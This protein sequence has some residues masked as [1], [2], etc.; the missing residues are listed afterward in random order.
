MAALA[1]GLAMVPLLHMSKVL[2]LRRLVPR[3]PKM[4]A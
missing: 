2:V 4:S 1:A 3:A